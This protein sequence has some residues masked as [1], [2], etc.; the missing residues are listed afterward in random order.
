MDL[1]R[2]SLAGN[3]RLVEPAIGLGNEPGRR[4]EAVSANRDHL[5][6]VDEAAT[7]PDQLERSHLVS[8]VPVT[9]KDAW[10][11]LAKNPFVVGFLQVSGL[12]TE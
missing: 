12:V 7:E 5:L 6:G 2:V 10:C 11:D 4:L 3:G 1:P 8:S 9:G